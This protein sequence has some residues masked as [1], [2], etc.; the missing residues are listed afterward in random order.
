MAKAKARALPSAVDAEMSVLGSIILEPTSFE[1]VLGI[2]AMDGEDFYHPA[3]KHIYSTLVGLHTKRVPIDVVT[4]SDALAGID[5][6]IVGGIAYI[7]ELAENTP[8]SANISYYAKIVRDKALRRKIII[9]S[10]DAI[11]QAFADELETK[12]IIENSQKKIMGLSLST[13]IKDYTTA[14]AL[15]PKVIDNLEALAKN[16]GG[17]SGMPTGIDDLDYLLGGMQNGDLIVIAGRPSM[18]KAQPLDAKLLTPVGWKSMGD[19]KIGDLVAGSDGEFNRITGVF[20]QGKKDI[21]RVKFTDGTSTECCD[22]H[23]W[24]TK[25]RNDRKS[26]R[27]G[28]VKTLREIRHTL[29]TDNKDKRLNH[30][31]PYVNPIRFK[32]KELPVDPYLLGLYLG[33]G[34]F[35]SSVV[36]TN[37]EIDLQDD[38]DSMVLSNG[39]TCRIKRDKSLQVGRRAVLAEHLVAL[40][41][42]RVGSHDKFIPKDYLFSSIDDRIQLLRGLVDTD[43]YIYDS[44]N[45]IEYVTTSIKLKEDIEF[46]VRSLGGRVTTWLKEPFYRKNNK[47]IPCHAAYRMNISFHNSKFIPVNSEKHLRRWKGSIRPINRMIESVE[48]IGQKECQCIM[49]DC[50]D[51]LYVTDDFILTHN[52]SLA[53][54]IG[55]NVSIAGK[56]VALFTPE[57]LEEQAVKNII[58]CQG[59]IDT[60]KFRDGQLDDKEW[61]KI[62]EVISRM[63]EG[64]FYID[65]SP[66]ISSYDIVTRCRKMKMDRGLD[67]IIID[68][69]SEIRENGNHDNREREVDYICS[70]L[71]GLAKELNIPVIL[72]A[73]LNRG[74][75]SRGG[76][77]RP[78]NSDLRDS[79]SVEQKADVIIFVY[80]EGYYF[81][82]KSTKGNIAEAIISKHRGGPIGTVELMWNPQYLRFDELWR[83]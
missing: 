14:K 28:T 59:R 30:S 45:G 60:T 78:R 71:K 58:A 61:G 62:S 12:Q 66:H 37:P 3:H 83:G 56:K 75:E 13:S 2:L 7:G 19:I 18:G 43:G 41:L 10:T 48:L 24:Y 36:F 77:F 64:T 39:M 38:K 74:V 5:L 46:L 17:F 47:R 70:N 79:G 1:K 33:D 76:D 49:V 31:V 20:P 55:S 52:S 67:L 82:E 73:Q 54:Q 4:I 40:G 44:G 26:N 57:V 35:S 32:A 8:T 9:E 16:G 29:R 68:H 22:E 81:K 27:S 63:Y 69:L 50:D 25:T 6:S 72:V 21:Y 65:D 11:E 34:Y 80:R 23:L 53:L 51:H 42:K 15:F